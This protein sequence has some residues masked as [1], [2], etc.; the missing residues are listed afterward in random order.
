MAARVR[1]SARARAAAD[2]ANR[3]VV[4]LLRD[5][6]R[7]RLAFHPSDDRMINAQIA[8]NRADDEAR[9]RARACREINRPRRLA[10]A[11]PGTPPRRELTTAL[12]AG[13]A[14]LWRGRRKL[15]P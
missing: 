15:T 5:T 3:T 8:Q 13:S 11:P 10:P 2:D 4:H 14:K 9:A 1:A 12:G 7:H 6:R